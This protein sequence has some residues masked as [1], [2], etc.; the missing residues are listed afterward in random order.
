MMSSMLRFPAAQN[1][2]LSKRSMKDKPVKKIERKCTN[3]VPSQK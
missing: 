3:N 1:R 2:Q